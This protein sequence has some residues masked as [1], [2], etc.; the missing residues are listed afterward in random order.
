VGGTGL[1]AGNPA[2]LWVQFVSV[3]VVGLYAFVLTYAI[4]WAIDK[5]VGLR[6][7]EEREVI[8]LDRELHGE[9]GYSL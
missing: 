9:V 2:Q 4:G 1:I 7:D 5:V 6:V 3:V 8:G